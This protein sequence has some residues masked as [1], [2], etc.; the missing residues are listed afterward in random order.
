MNKPVG[1]LVGT[2]ITGLD[3]GGNVGLHVLIRH[4]NEL[5]FVIV[6]IVEMVDFVVI[7]MNSVVVIVGF[8]LGV[9]VGSEVVII[10]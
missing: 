6:L 2:I 7:V 1:E 5:I 9:P 4:H 3:V 10:C 8:V